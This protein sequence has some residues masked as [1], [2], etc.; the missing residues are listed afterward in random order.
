MIARFVLMAGFVVSVAIA[1]VAQDE[2]KVAARAE[3]N[4]GVQAYKQ[5]D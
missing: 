3:L 5:A 1:G 4:S 2:S